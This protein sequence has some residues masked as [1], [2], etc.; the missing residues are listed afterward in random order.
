MM[1]TLVENGKLVG[2]VLMTPSQIS[3]FFFIATFI[4]APILTIIEAFIGIW[5]D[6]SHTGISV[7]LVIADSL[8]FLGPFVLVIGV[9]IDFYR[10]DKDESFEWRAFE[11]ASFIFFTVGGAILVTGSALYTGNKFVVAAILWTIATAIFTLA[12]FMK[13]LVDQQLI[14]HLHK[15]EEA[16]YGM[17]VVPSEETFTLKEWMLW[18]LVVGQNF[19][20]LGS[21]SFLIGSPL[22]LVGTHKFNVTGNILWI[23]GSFLIIIG[24]LFKTIYVVLQVKLSRN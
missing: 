9:S 12:S 15:L 11:L 21:V 7:L 14:S 24:S 19:Y 10:S 16:E 22:Y 23:I 20:L 5:S 3:A 8:F 18:A 4:V 17:L 6:G 2:E 13:L 1:T